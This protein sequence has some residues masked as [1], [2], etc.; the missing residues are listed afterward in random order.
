MSGSSERQP[1]GFDFWRRWLLVV[2]LMFTIVGLAIAIVPDAPLLA[3]HTSAL[4]RVF[5]GG[6]MPE[7]AAQLRR[8]LLGPLG[9][10]IAGYF[11]LQA[12]VVS[13]PFRRREP[14]AWHAVLWPMLL[15]F[16]VDSGMSVYHGAFFNVWMINVW[17]LLL[18]G[19]PLAMTRRAFGGRL[20]A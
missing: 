20:M 13:G 12:F 9:G 19:L 8:L 4:E 10:T 17:T 1:D 18:V 3:V 11:L 15:W 7:P 14:W 5:F 2:S 16:V 6:S